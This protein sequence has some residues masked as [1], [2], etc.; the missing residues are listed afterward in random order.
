MSLT[1]NIRKRIFYI[2]GGPG[3][4]SLAESELLTPHFENNQVIPY[5]W[6]ETSGTDFTELCA[7]AKQHF[8]DLLPGSIHV[9]AHSFGLFPA[10]ELLAQFDANAISR[11]TVIAPPPDLHKCHQNILKL[12]LDDFSNPDS[13]D[14]ESAEALRV[15]LNHAQTFYDR[16]I[17]TGFDLAS[18]DTQL[19]THYWKNS[20]V[21]AFK[22][23][24]AELNRRSNETGSLFP[25]VLPK[26]TFP[27]TLLFGKND[28][29]IHYSEQKGLC[30]T[31]FPDAEIVFFENSGH[32]P[33]FEE[34]EQFIQ[35]C[36]KT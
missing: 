14:N 29:I 12:A 16:H 24:L 19:F 28:P 33:H 17:E 22:N 7:Q 23:T 18:K 30:K 9:I 32:F 25:S 31:I 35:E 10:L 27:V 13:A 5:F 36:I 11:L 1:K 4:H 15:C 2:H 8:S 26:S 20:D 3:F 6:N 34:V 21:L